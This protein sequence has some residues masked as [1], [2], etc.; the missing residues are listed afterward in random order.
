MPCQRPLKMFH[1]S[2]CAGLNLERLGDDI[3]IFGGIVGL[4]GGE[5]SRRA[6]AIS[7][8]NVAFPARKGDVLGRILHYF[9]S[10]ACHS[11]PADEDGIDRRGGGRSIRKMAAAARQRAPSRISPTPPNRADRRPGKR[12]ACRPMR[13]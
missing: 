11:G 2:C 8:K 3:S 9:R 5:E 6:P 10:S 1:L 7:P 13:G 12:S 4:L